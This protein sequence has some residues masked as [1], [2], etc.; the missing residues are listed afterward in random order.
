MKYFIICTAFSL[1]TLAACKS[2]GKENK[3]NVTIPEMKTESPAGTSVTQLEFPSADGLLISATLYEKDSAAPVILLCHQAGFN[4]YEYAEIAPKLVEL[5]FTCLAIN[6]RSGG[7]MNENKNNTF[8]RAKEKNLPTD[9]EA[10]E[11]DIV[12]AIDY[13][14]ALHNSPILLWGSSYSASLA[15]ITANKNEKV[16]AVIAFSPGEYLQ[17]KHKLSNGVEG[18]VKS[19]FVACTEKESGAA[20]KIID[21]IDEQYVTFYY[22]DT[23]GTHGSKALWSSDPAHELYWNA[24]KDFLIKNK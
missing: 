23:K 10:A 11:Q 5:G 4:S 19:V 14:F 12:A 7:D 15:L 1:T 9:Y 13:A 2:G 6:Q 18:F 22:P 3:E 21:K 20:G 17:D 8:E 16:K 24:V